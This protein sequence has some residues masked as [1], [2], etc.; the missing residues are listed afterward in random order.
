MLSGV[1]GGGQFD[2]LWRGYHRL[3]PDVQ[4]NTTRN[5]ATT[6]AQFS[7]QLKAKLSGSVTEVAQGLRMIASLKNIAP[8]REHIV[9]LCAH[10]DPRIISSAIKLIGRMEDP[11][12]HDLLEAA[13]Q[14]SDPRVRANAVEA[15]EVLHIAHTSQQVLH[16]LTSRHNRERANAIKALSRFNVGMAHDCLLKML[17]D[18]NPLHRISALWVVS[19]LDMF[20]VIRH[21]GVM[22]RK[23]PNMKVRNRADELLQTLHA[24]ANS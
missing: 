13:A 24:A 2:A 23:D 4:Q 16:M 19:Q 18:S 11:R 9:G 12:F 15:M 14:H 21:V 1:T 17:A 3:P 5:A 22:A 7:E 8:Y 6:D 20:E 10:Q